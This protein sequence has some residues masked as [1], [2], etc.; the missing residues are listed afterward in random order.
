VASEE[1]GQAQRVEVQRAI[2]GAQDGEQT[3]DAWLS[4]QA[5]GRAGRR[6]AERP[7]GRNGQ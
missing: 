2:D 4:S 1:G 3:A 7:E 5:D 6:G